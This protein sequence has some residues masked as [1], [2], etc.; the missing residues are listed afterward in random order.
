MRKRDLPKRERSDGERRL[1]TVNSERHCGRTV[2]GGWRSTFGLEG[3]EA[4]LLEV[5]IGE[6]DFEPAQRLMY[7]WQCEVERSKPAIK[8]RLAVC[9]ERS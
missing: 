6:I 5:N 7:V 9:E 2:N 3:I 8:R 1:Q 4:D